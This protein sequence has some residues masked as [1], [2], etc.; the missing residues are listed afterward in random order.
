MII[1]LVSTVH[2]ESIWIRSMEIANH[3]QPIALNVTRQIFGVHPQ[4]VKLAKL[5]EALLTYQNGNVGLI[6]MRLHTMIGAGVHV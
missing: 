1:I 6:V 5:Q 2:Q 4:I 3:A